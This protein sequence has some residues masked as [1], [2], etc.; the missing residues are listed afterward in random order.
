MK[1]S[2]LVALVVACA[3][4]MPLLAEP[5][6]EGVPGAPPPGM[7]EPKRAPGGPGERAGGLNKE[8]RDKLRVA[9]E[10]ALE[11]PEVKAAEEEMREAQKNFNAKLNQEMLKIDP[12][13]EPTLKKLENRP[14]GLRRGGPPPRDGA[15]P[16]GP[17]EHDEKKGGEAEE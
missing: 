12:R 15:K 7:E 5:Q 13:L 3:S 17:R 11:N 6:G 8:E 10:K 16:G 4:A 9:R 1:K 14:R 2:M